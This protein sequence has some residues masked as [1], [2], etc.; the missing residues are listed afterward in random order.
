MTRVG[1]GSKS[2]PTDVTRALLRLQTQD[3]LFHLHQKQSSNTRKIHYSLRFQTTQH[4]ASQ[5]HQ[6]GC[7]LTLFQRFFFFVFILKAIQGRQSSLQQ[8]HRHTSVQNNN[9]TD[10]SLSLRH[11]RERKR[12]T[13][14]YKTAQ[15]S[16]L[17]RLKVSGRSLELHSQSKIQI[18]VGFSKFQ[19]NS[20]R[21]D[22]K[23]PHL[24]LR[25]HRGISTECGGLIM[26]NNNYQ[27]GSKGKERSKGKSIGDH[28]C[29]IPHVEGL[30]INQK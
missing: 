16:C 19:P 9:K 18:S 6:N 4:L 13:Y 25:Q 5:T 22:K 3:G 12:Q 17:G 29:Q 7:H 27:S 2:E 10:K 14:T 30:E 23:K 26:C 11:R 24:K 15:S 8:S 28:E 21:P 20:R 1:G